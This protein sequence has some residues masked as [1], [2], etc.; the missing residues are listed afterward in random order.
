MALRRPALQAWPLWLLLHVAFSGE[1]KKQPHGQVWELFEGLGAQQVEV[2]YIRH[3]ESIWNAERQFLHGTLTEEEIVRRGHEPV[4]NDSPL[5]IKGVVQARKLA[6]NLFGAPGSP[7]PPARPGSAS[8]PPQTTQLSQIVACAASGQ[9]EAPLLLTSN[10]RRA[11]DTMVI[12]MRPLL[13]HN[14][15]LR[16][17]AVPTLQETATYADCTPLP[18]GMDGTVLF[19][20]PHEVYAPDVASV[21]QQQHYALKQALN[22]S[23]EAVQ[24]IGFMRNLYKHRCAPE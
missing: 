16:V 6:E 10:L 17:V 20:P 23:F 4:H 3:G 9:C 1:V 2:F 15:D 22:D 12:G 5:S 24:L 8:V 11:I 19:D 18:L 21:L 14:N 7:S 13:V